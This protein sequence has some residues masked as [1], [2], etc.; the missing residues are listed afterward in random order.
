MAHPL[1]GLHLH[2]PDGREDREHVGAGDLG[3]GPVADAPE[4]VAF[5]ASHPGL[6]V[7]GVSPAGPLRR[8]Q[9][10]GGA[11]RWGKR[12]APVVSMANEIRPSGAALGAR[13]L[14]S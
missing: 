12:T 6:R 13:S 8:H 9:G 4:H 2:V 14:Y 1:G 7:C 10:I 3:D 11:A 5:E